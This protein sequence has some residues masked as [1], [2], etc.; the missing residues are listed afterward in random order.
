MTQTRTLSVAGAAFVALVTGCQPT[1]T[2]EP[3][4][5]SH[6]T[7]APT[8]MP[9]V[10]P[11][12]GNFEG[13]VRE[14]LDAGSYTYLLVGTDAGAEEWVVTLGKGANVGAQVAI[15]S[16]GTRRDFES[17]RLKRRFDRLVFAI[18]LDRS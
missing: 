7:P 11:P 6:E 8:G 1:P 5:T 17:A 2:P 13:Q 18:V 10:D 15:K 4:A 16:M 3:A 12:E 14:R 9:Q